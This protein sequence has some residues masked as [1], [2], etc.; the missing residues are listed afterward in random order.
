MKTLIGISKKQFIHYSILPEKEV[1]DNV[2]N[3]WQR[4]K[5]F[6]IDHS[7]KVLPLLTNKNEVISKITDRMLYLW[8]HTIN[9]H[10]SLNMFLD[11][12]GA[13]LLWINDDMIVFNKGGNKE[14]LAAL[15]EKNIRFGTNFSEKLIGTNAVSLAFSSGNPEWV[16]GEEHY[17][18]A[19]SDYAMLSMPPIPNTFC[20][21]N[22][23]AMIIS[24]DK[25]N[26]Y[27]KS[28]FEYALETFQVFMNYRS[29]PDV[30]IKNKILSE[31]MEQN[32]NLYIIVD[33][34]GLIIEANDLLYSIFN[35]SIQEICGKRLDTVFPELAGTLDCLK[36]LKR[37]QQMSVTFYNQPNGYNEY[38]VDCTPVVKTK[39][40]IFGMTVILTN[41]KKLQKFCHTITNKSPHYTFDLLIGESKIF[42][43]TVAF[44]MQAAKSP[45]TV[46]IT[47]ESGTG[48]ELFAQSIHNASSRKTYPFIPLNCAA[49]PK[50]LI[51]SE[52]F[53]YVE[54]AFTGAKKRG[55]PGK[56]EIA[57]GGTIFLD[58]IAEMPL[59]MQAVLLRV[60]EDRTVTRIGD[61]RAIAVDVRIIAATNRNLWE[62]VVA[63]KFR[64]DLYFRLNVLNLELPPLRKRVEDL[65]LLVD[66]FL[67]SFSVSFGKNIR[68]VEPEVIEVFSQYNWPGNIR[69]LRNII[70]RGVNSTESDALT[71][72][73]LPAD[74]LATHKEESAFIHKE[75][76]PFQD[77]NF[78]S[79]DEYEK[80]LIRQLLIKHKGNKSAVSSEMGISRKSLYHKLRKYESR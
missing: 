54:G 43:D 41:R 38:I 3:S 32:S 46:L 37:I 79:Y 28:A 25:Y 80:K 19:L 78:S 77:N 72:R 8:H 73:D 48:K 63:G 14:F 65:P 16:V 56:F 4:S 55:T 33:P 10:I 59:D 6:N 13:A 7:M 39:D 61:S 58:E 69:E 42:K 49:I 15:K 26:S 51:G 29:L 62:Y 45:S 74:F 70:E 30:F 24:I 76:I 36:T 57:D 47:G 53:G 50:E 21:T 67:K 17:T 71:L 40:N 18:D 60:L 2:I 20:K 31:V 1:R 44:A 9:F 66:D 68:R 23:I 35:K 64:H 52:L 5:A 75:S 34:N 11:N 12:L 27:F 22:C